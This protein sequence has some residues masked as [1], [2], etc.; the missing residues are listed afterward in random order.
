MANPARGEARVRIGDRDFTLAYD[1][2]ALCEV[3]LLL[4][5][6]LQSILERL[7][8]P[9]LRDMRALLWAGLQRHHPMSVAEAGDLLGEVLRSGA[10]AT[11]ALG[12]QLSEGIAAAFPP[13]AA[14]P[15]TATPA[16]P[17]GKRSM[18][19][20]SKPASNPAAP[21]A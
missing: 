18:R 14:S 16:T 7:A 20:Q 6:P 5:M 4:G 1:L 13:P 21:G 2:N 12:Q 10:D 15:A 3:E 9:R 19:Q 8:Q 17:T 11:A